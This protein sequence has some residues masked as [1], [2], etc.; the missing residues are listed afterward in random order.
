MTPGGLERNCSFNT[1]CPY[2]TKAQRVS[3]SPRHL[4]PLDE[5]LADHL[6]DSR[7]GEARGGWLAIAA[8]VSVV[9]DIAL[10]VL[11]VAETGR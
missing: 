1:A 2:L 6:V 9:H 4:L 11:R 7:L 8:A 5:M 3:R 10:V